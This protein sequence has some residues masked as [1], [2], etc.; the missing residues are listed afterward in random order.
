MLFVYLMVLLVTMVPPI[1]VLQTVIAAA[2]TSTNFDL[3][4]AL[5][6]AMVQVLACRGVSAKRV[7][8]CLTFSC[9]KQRALICYPDIGIAA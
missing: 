7:L 4:E 6:D 9:A 1:H 5:L 2:K 8:T 3:P